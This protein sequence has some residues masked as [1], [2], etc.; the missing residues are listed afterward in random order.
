M[1][2]K[3]TGDM[4]VQSL[5]CDKQSN[6]QRNEWA[7]LIGHDNSSNRTGD[8]LVQSLENQLITISSPFG[9]SVEF[10]KC[11]W[12]EATFPKFSENRAGAV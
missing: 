3:Q 12:Q 11:L 1:T 10:C 5:V 2:V 4:L 7:D 9:Q 6:Q 8:M